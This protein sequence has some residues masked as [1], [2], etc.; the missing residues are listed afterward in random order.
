MSGHQIQETRETKLVMLANSV[1]KRTG[2]QLKQLK[3]WEVKVQ[4]PYPYSE[5][6]EAYRAEL[7]KQLK[8]DEV[9][10]TKNYKQLVL[11]TEFK[12][13]NRTFGDKYKPVAIEYAVITKYIYNSRVYLTTKDTLELPYSE[14]HK[15]RAD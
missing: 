9:E 11:Y 2:Q 12:E 8:A 4:S 10:I 14:I 15:P 1:V 5:L 3:L 6:G 13:I 7:T